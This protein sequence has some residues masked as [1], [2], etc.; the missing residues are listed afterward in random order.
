MRCEQA[1][2]VGRSLTYIT[3]PHRTPW[4]RAQQ[5]PHPNAR[6]AECCTCTGLHPLA[7]SSGRSDIRNPSTGGMSSP[8]L[9]PQLRPSVSSRLSIAISTRSAE[10]GG[11]EHPQEHIEEIDEI[12]RYEVSWFPRGYL[13]GWANWSGV[14]GLYNNRF[15]SLRVSFC[16]TVIAHT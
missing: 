7:S 6:V 14:A 15:E 3:W 11:V 13:R 5:E 1:S 8:R 9:R 12:R 4:H 16:L 10:A 2:N